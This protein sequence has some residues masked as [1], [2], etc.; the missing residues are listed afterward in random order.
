MSI[1]TEP[2]GL[3]EVEILDA[4][5]ERVL[6]RSAAQG[7]LL[8]KVRRKDACTTAARVW[9][10]D[11]P[12]LRETARDCGGSVRV[13]RLRG[14]SRIR[15]SLRTRWWLLASLLISAALLAVSSLF[16]WEIR[17]CGC[18]TLSEGQV[19]RALAD[20]GVERGCFWPGISAD[21]VRSRMLTELPELGWMTVN[22]SGS[23][24]TVLVSER[25]EKPE[26]Y[27]EERAADIVAA[28]TGQIRSVT[29][30]NGRALV[31]P[32]DAVLAGE[33]LV[34]GTV[35]SLTRPERHVRALAEIQADT[36]VEL[37][38][39]CPREMLSLQ[40]SDTPHSRFSVQFG[41]HRRVFSVFLRKGLDESEKI[42]HEYILG[43]GGLFSFPVTLIR[44]EWRS[45]TPS[46]GEASR[47][48][49]MKA[50]LLRRLEE[51]TDGEIL[52]H[53]Y[54]VGW[55]EELLTVTLRAHCLENIA[56][57]AEIP[58]P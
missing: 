10:R 25:K 27:E 50:A 57:T 23:R 17:V 3:A 33:L 14:G 53:S 54:S 5:P 40:E 36:W 48:E 7:V 39:V 12:V 18:E 29:V 21:L 1:K 37:T 47:E 26:I 13:Q 24:A 22:L 9:E 41:S 15:Q 32:G 45:R 6:E 30:L 51:Q 58:S 56:Q 42:R 16:V 31:Q 46:S 52:S 43:V 11:L 44:E 49:E 55:T 38:A 34:S 8:M 20:C 19:L 4:E 2:L 35:E 28:K